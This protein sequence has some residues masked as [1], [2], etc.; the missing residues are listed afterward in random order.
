MKGVFITGT[1]TDVGKTWVGI[2]IIRALLAT[3]IEVIP[4][5]PVESGWNQEITNTDAWKIANA[6]GKLA[7][8][9]EVCPYHF[10]QV[11]SP[12][13][14]ALREGCTLTI[15][16]LV[17]QCLN[18]TQKNNFLYIEGAGGFYSPLASDGL[19]MDMAKS[20]N[21]PVIL[22]AENR[23]GCINQVLLSVEAIHQSGLKLAA[24]V[25]NQLDSNKQSGLNRGIDATN[26]ITDVMSYIKEPVISVNYLEKKE[27]P[28]N[29]IARLLAH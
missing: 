4:R 29:Q 3:G 18:N 23:L 7:Q 16:Q 6:A 19:N 22:V 20:L 12:V 25:L 5:K 15:D 24:V 11:A 26:N 8:L 14:A 2:R 17:R 28:F 1:D 10:D 13:R 9:D 21:L 27:E